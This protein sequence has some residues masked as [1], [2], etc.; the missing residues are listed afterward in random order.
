MYLSI[1]PHV[2]SFTDSEG[3]FGNGPWNFCFGLTESTTTP[4]LLLCLFWSP[5][6]SVIHLFARDLCML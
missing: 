3:F 1:Y 2:E 6:P 4:T 5:V